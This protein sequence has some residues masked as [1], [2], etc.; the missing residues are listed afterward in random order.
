MPKRI[1]PQILII[2]SKHGAS[3]ISIIIPPRKAI[4]ET[5]KM[6]N[7]EKG[8]AENIKNKVNSKSV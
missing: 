5:T 3:M 7:E 2:H 8:K 6:L 4:T 1:S